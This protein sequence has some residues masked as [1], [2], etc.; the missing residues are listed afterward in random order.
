[1]ALKLP[2]PSVVVLIGPSGSGKTTW[3]LDHF[4]PNEVLSSDGL[5]ATVGIDE[6]DQK[7]GTV[8]FA[9]LDQIV[10]ER[11]R[12]G[13]S[14]V[15]DT[16]GLNAENR[17]RWVE[18]A[19]GGGLPAYA[20]LFDTP[21]E[22]CEQRNRQRSRPVPKSALR[23]QISKF[24][25]VAKA[26]DAEHFDGVHTQQPIALVIPRVARAA[27]TVREVHTERRHTFGLQLSRF[28]G[29]GDLASDVRS[30][31]IR[32]EEA[33]FTDIWVMD[34]FRQIPQVGRVWE[35]I[36]EAYVTLAY[37]ASATKSIRLGTLVT[38]VTHRNPVV[39]GKTIAS[40]DSLSG[41]RA[42]CGIGI[43]WDRAE[44]QSYGID[45]PPVGRRYEILEETL[46]MLPLLWGPGSPEF[47]GRHIRATELT[48]YPRPSQEKIPIL[49]GGSGERRTLKLVAEYADA[50]NLF[51]D[52]ETVAHKIKVLHG[53]CASI[54]RD[55]GEITVT[56]LISALAGRDRAELRGRIDD[57]RDRNTS[58]EEYARRYNA[59][60][61]DDIVELLS[62]YDVAGAHHSIVA[63]P[64]VF[65]EGSIETF[66]DVIASFGRP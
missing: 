20:V 63:L 45:F 46:Q 64:D 23:K 18:L 32:A 34:H 5:R 58:V 50:S 40:L 42:I 57:L 7:A 61:V 39:L 11:V 35:P 15:I 24:R 54:D 59:G 60:T 26:I 14:T 19:H 52:P 22:V 48:C 21:P 62:S 28:E 27:P 33:G 12:R 16:T 4:A 30:L 53:H 44:H 2:A 3:A 38:G 8:A 36:T 1:M 13:L 31:A 49:I 56:H 17:Q 47:M 43:G 37:M 55:P 25:S 66:G 10:T 51:G 29:A 6:T 9:L 65:A 41:G